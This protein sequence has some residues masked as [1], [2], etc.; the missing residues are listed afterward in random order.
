MGMQYGA[1]TVENSVLD[2]H[3][4]NTEL[5][6]GPEVSFWC[7]SQEYKTHNEVNGCTSILTEALF[8]IANL[9]KQ[10]PKPPTG[11]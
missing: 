8:I 2:P 1:A 4:L 3:K 10:P 7:T 5:P 6:R 9:R 11:E